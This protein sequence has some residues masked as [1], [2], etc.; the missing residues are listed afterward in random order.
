MTDVFVVASLAI[1]IQMGENESS[2]ASPANITH[3]KRV[4]RLWLIPLLAVGAWMT[5]DN[6]A[7]LGPLN[8]IEF[9]AS[10]GLEAGKRMA[11]VMPSGR[12]TNYSTTSL[13]TS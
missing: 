10:E 6:W 2:N 9:D 13:P 3:G 4:L 11:I 1:F 8:T 5:Y 12:L 7:R